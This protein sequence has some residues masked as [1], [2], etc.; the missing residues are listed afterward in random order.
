MN[1][2]EYSKIVKKNEFIVRY[3]LAPAPLA[4]DKQN[5]TIGGLCRHI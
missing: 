5:L 1:R 2:R 4:G 3:P